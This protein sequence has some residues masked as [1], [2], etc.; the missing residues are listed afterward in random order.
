M[1]RIAHRELRNQSSK[2]LEEVSKGGVVEVTN[3]GEVVAVI[4]PPKRSRYDLLVAA[5]Q[6]RPGR[7]TDQ[8]WSAIP[9]TEPEEDS[10]VALDELRS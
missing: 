10:I 6:I 5:G 2:I 8:L 7:D 4:V 1:R 3:H 9:T